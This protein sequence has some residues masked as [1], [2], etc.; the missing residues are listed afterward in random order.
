MALGDWDTLIHWLRGD[1]ERRMRFEGVTGL[2]IA[3][4]DDQRVAWSH[5]AGWADR[6]AHIPVTPRTP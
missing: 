2:S 3:I 1:I 6:E 4:V 5:A